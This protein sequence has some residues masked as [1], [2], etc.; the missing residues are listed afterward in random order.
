MGKRV[1]DVAVVMAGALGAVARFVLDSQIS[2]HSDDRFPLGILVVNLTG[3]LFLGVVAGLVLAHGVDSDL[4][5]VL[6]VGF[7]G[8]YTTYS[9][10]AFDTVA[11]AG[12][13]R[14]AVAIGYPLLTV[15]GSCG[16]AA[17]GL[18]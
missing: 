3:S 11:A 16:A 5:T 18:M 1:I 7:C 10:F 17:L 6:G 15:A 8:G 4:Q 14:S 12:E 2:K 13:G 9:T